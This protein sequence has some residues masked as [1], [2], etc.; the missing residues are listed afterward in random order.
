MFFRRKKKK[1]TPG[2]SALEKYTLFFEVLPSEPR[3]F[4]KKK[5]PKKKKS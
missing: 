4:R 1:A 2:P 3:I 5:T